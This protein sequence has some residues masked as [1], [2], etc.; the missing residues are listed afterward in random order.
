M[1]ILELEAFQETRAQEGKSN[2][3]IPVKSE[4]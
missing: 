4:E 2:A 3:G 1:L